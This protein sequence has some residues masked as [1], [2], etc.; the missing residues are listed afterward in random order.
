MLD[1]D[2]ILRALERLAGILRER[3]TEGEICLLAHLRISTP[4]AALAV[5]GRFYSPDQVPPR[6]QYLLES[7]LAEE[8]AHRGRALRAT[9]LAESPAPFR[10]RNLFVS[11]NALSRA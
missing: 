3:G 7:I 2:R 11:A 8:F 4:D 10:E 1:R 6:T 9:L 5:V